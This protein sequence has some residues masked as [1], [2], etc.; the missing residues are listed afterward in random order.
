MQNN[1]ILKKGKSY[2]LFFN[3]YMIGYNANRFR[4]V[5]RLDFGGIPFV[6]TSS[7]TTDTTNSEV[8]YGINP[9]LF[10]RLPNQGILLLSVNHVPAAGSDGYLVSVATT[11]TNTTSTSTSKVPLVN[12]S[13]DQ[14]PSSEISQGNKYFVY[15][16]ITSRYFV[17]N[18][19]TISNIS[20]YL[21][22][23]AKTV[24]DK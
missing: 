11:L 6:R 9:C 16:D 17:T 15:Y 20:T 13:G 10:R 14:I 5:H 23:T 8:I 7:V 24:T 21:N 4:G 18:P 1:K 19:S 22:I 12:G 2:E 3:P